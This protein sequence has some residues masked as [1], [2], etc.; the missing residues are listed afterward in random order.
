MLLISLA[1]SQ[2]CSGTAASVPDPSCPARTCCQTYY[3]CIGGTPFLS[4]SIN[5]LTVFMKSL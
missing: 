2:N 1:A 4:V 3:Q 5:F